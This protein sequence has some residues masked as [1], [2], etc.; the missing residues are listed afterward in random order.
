MRG[1]IGQLTA[2]PLP[3]AAVRQEDAGPAGHRQEDPQ[4]RRD[5]DRPDQ[6][7]PGGVEGQAKAG[8]VKPTSS[9]TPGHDDRGPGQPRRALP[10]PDAAEYEHGDLL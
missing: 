4:R 9:H 10:L 7:H 2:E 5:L 8:L 1:Q 3:E 6:L